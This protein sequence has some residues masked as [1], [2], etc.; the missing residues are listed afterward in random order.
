QV[1]LL[2]LIPEK[3]QE[4]RV[5]AVWGASG[6]PRKMSIVRRAYDD[7]KRNNNFG[8]YAWIRVTH[9]ISPSE[10]LHRIMFQFYMNSHEEAGNRGEATTVG[11]QVLNMM[12]MMEE[13][14]LVDQFNQH[15]S[16]N[17]YLIVL[18]DLSTI[19]DWD[20]IK[21]YFPNNKKRSRII[22][23]TEQTEVASL[24]AGPHKMVV[25][26]KQSSANQTI[27]AFC[28]KDT[29]KP[30]DS[31]K[32]VATNSSTPPEGNGLNL[33]ETTMDVD[34]LKESHLIG[35]QGQVSDIIKLICHEQSKDQPEVN[36][37]N[38]ESQDQL[39]VISLCGKSGL[40]KTTLVKYIYQHQELDGMFEKRAC[41]TI[42][43][44]FNYREL[45]RSLA[46]QLFDDNKEDLVK[47]ETTKRE[48]PQWWVSQLENKKYLIVLDDLSSTREWDDIKKYFP[49][50]KKAS[51]IIV[52]TGGEEIAKHCSKDKNIF[53]LRSL[54]NGD[55]HNLFVKKE[56]DVKLGSWGRPFFISKK[57]RMLRVLDLEGTSGL[58]DHDLE[59]IGKLLQL[60]YLSLRGC[61]D[62]CHLPHSL[63]NLRQLETLDIKHTAVIR[64]PK[65]IIH[66][67][68]LQYLR[69]GGHGAFGGTP[70]EEFV[71][72]LP[73]L[74]G[75]KLCLLPLCSVACCCVA[76]CKPQA[77]RSGLWETGGD[78]NMR[79]VC[80]AWCCTV[81]PF[82]ARRLDPRG[83]LV[84]GGVNMLTVLHTLGT[85]NISRRHRGKAVLRDI[86]Q[87]TRLRKLGVAGVS[88]EGNSKELCWA[89]AALGS[90]ESL[91]VLSAGEKGLEGCLESEALV[92]S[93]PMNLKSLKLDG[94]LVRLPGWISEL[95]NLVKLSLRR[96]R[97]LLVD[98]E[99]EEKT[100]AMGILARLPNLTILRLQQESFQGEDLSFTFRNREEFPNLK[101]LQLIL[102]SG[103]KSVKFEEGAMPKLELLQFCSWPSRT[104]ANFF[105]GL[106]SLPGL[107]R[108]LLDDDT[109]Y[110]KEFIEGLRKQLSDNPKKPTL[111]RYVQLSR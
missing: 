29:T 91:S 85:V 28:E 30:G 7:L 2:P 100:T 39:E 12:G 84:P 51:R 15:V 40:G 108:F 27:Y 82:V 19:E 5:I 54:E 79:D 56:K 17:S 43:H 80:T 111:K 22:V 105:S 99:R 14:D 50:T 26:L 47:D 11:A 70:Y 8:C 31:S 106:D 13:D 71:E 16:Q 25:E 67:S 36:S 64:L 77:A 69:V 68:K 1:D 18:N 57:M 110:S 38:R 65:A 10:F 101:V 21:T 46:T 98:N 49:E 33:T 88:A 96:S 44:P 109:T 103:L 20:W 35:R 45:I 78:P 3:D 89:L 52:T 59:H 104:G 6:D 87:L 37:E 48:D 24:C 42:K 23:S 95:R 32:T 83:V 58:N 60:K 41:V 61:L 75:S 66:L 81:F 73:R 74:L 4:L 76:C 102:V 34:S 63:G 9:P 92:C 94:N 55:V 62:I 107:K 72:G 93:P 86:A 97:L 53:R 90:L